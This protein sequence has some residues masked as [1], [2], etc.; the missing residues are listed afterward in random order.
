MLPLTTVTTPACGAR[1]SNT[2]S[3]TPSTPVAS[4]ALAAPF[5]NTACC[6]GDNL[7]SVGTFTPASKSSS[8]FCESPPLAESTPEIAPR[9]APNLPSGVV[10]SNLPSEITSGVSVVMSPTPNALL[11]SSLA[12]KIAAASGA[13][14]AFSTAMLVNA[15]MFNTNAAPFETPPAC[16]KALRSLPSCV[17]V[18]V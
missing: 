2:A 11:T 3:T 12:V 18:S 7:P 17:T 4:S 8:V 1:L 10:P 16:N 14:P 9:T 15:L 6:S 13:V 5:S